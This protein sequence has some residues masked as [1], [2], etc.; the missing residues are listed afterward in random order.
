MPNE[1]LYNLE[2]K[3]DVNIAKW[4]IDDQTVEDN[5][6]WALWVYDRLQ[7]KWIDTSEMSRPGEE[8]SIVELTQR[9]V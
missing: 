9:G 6:E 7:G 3:F 5:R 2:I 4:R 1:D 8:V